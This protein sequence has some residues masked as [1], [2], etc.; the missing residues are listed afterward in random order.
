MKVWKATRMRSDDTWCIPNGE[1]IMV[2]KKSNFAFILIDLKF[3][4]FFLLTFII[5]V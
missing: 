5:L 4:F 2:S 3:I 1:E